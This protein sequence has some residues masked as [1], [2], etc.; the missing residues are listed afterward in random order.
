[1]RYAGHVVRKGV[2]LILLGMKP[3]WHTAAD[4]QELY[5][6]VHINLHNEK[7]LFSEEI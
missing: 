6:R 3:V 7:E 4:L 2:Q 5:K 1:M